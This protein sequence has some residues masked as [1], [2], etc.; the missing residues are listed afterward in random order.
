MDHAESVGLYKFDE[1]P[2]ISNLSDNC[3]ELGFF[4]FFDLLFKELQQL[5]LHGFPF[6]FGAVYFS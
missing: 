4:R 6:R 1:H 5:D 3:G 2:V